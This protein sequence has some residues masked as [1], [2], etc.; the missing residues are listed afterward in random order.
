MEYIRCHS[1]DTW[2]LLDIGADNVEKRMKPEVELNT[3]LLGL[4]HWEVIVCFPPGF[5][6]I[7]STNIPPLAY[8]VSG[9]LM[10]LSVVQVHILVS[11]VKW[12]FQLG[13]YVPRHTSYT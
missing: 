7:S 9:S 12:G 6:L 3:D 5:A 4:F 1:I 10:F 8:G 11:W 13:C 2:E